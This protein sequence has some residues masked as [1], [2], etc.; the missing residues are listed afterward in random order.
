MI[1]KYSQ[2][3]KRLLPL[4]KEAEKIDNPVNFM[5]STEGLDKAAFGFSDGDILK[6]NPEKLNIKYPGDMDNVFYQIAHSGLSP[7]KWAKTVSLKTPIQVSFENGV[8]NIEDGHHRYYAA[9]LLGKP[10]FA[11]VNIKDNPLSVLTDLSWD[12]FNEY[13]WK[14]AHNKHTAKKDNLLIVSLPG[15]YVERKIPVY[16]NPSPEAYTEIAKRFR[17]E[18]PFAPKGEPKSRHTYDEKGNEYLWMSGDA[19]HY[20]MENAL[21]KQYGIKTHQIKGELP[22]GKFDDYS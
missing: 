15:K 21:Y 7:E 11:E 16:K 5:V 6:L 18:F 12:D 9:K 4:I 20:T 8:F 13:I 2:L 10:L 22:E 17:E 19:M 3:K 1:K 14:L